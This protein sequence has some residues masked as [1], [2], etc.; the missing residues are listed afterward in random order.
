MSY[1]NNTPPGSSELDVDEILQRVLRWFSQRG[2]G[3]YLLILVV[4]IVLWLTSGIYVV[5]AGEE[6]VV[7]TFGSF[8]NVTTPGLNYHL[9]RPFQKVT[10][11]DVDTVRRQEIGFRSDTSGRREELSEALMLTEDENIVQV[12]LVIQYRIGESD[13]FLFSVQNPEDVL[14]TSAEVSLRSTVGQMTIDAVITEERARVQEETRARLIELMDAYGTGILIANVQ[15]QVADPPVEVRDAF[16]EVVRALAD[17]E[18]LI[19]ESQAYQN[20]LVPRA[21]GR[22]QRLIEEAGAFKDQE[23]LR[24]T[25]DAKRFLSVLEAY[26]TA[27]EVTRERLHIEALENILQNVEM[28]LLDKA[29]VGGQVLPFLP[30]GDLNSNG[31]PATQR[32]TTTAPQPPTTESESTQ[33]E[34]N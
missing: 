22:K 13:K 34:G 12:E 5:N 28:T 4:L 14:L 20:D 23:I 25:G 18:R 21:R 9:P 1:N 29:A 8:S 33:Q 11:V 3:L 15:L 32:P 10:I 2:S 24:A 26:N 31:S 16:Q 19:N 30:L 27:P 6:G 7:Q 17:R